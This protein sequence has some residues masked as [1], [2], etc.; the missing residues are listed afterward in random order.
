[1][2]FILDWPMIPIEEV[3]WVLSM[4]AVYSSPLS[5]TTICSSP[6][7]LVCYHSFQTQVCGTSILRLGALFLVRR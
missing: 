6:S 3:G 5:V 2:P 7:M 4:L 1:M